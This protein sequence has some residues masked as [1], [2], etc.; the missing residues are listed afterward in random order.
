MIEHHRSRENLGRGVGDILASDIG[1]GAV[2][3]LKDCA[4]GTDVGA[5]CHAQTTHQ[6]GAQVAHD[7]AVQVGQHQDIE[8]IGVLDQAHAGGVDDLVVELDIGIAGGHLA[9]HAQE[10]AVGRLH[11][12]W[13]CARPSPFA[14]AAAGVLKGILH[15]ATAL[16]DGDRLDRDGG[17]G[18]EGLLARALDK[19]RELLD[20]GSALIEL[21]AGVE[22]LGVLA[23]DDQ[24][25]SRKREPSP[26]CDRQGRT[27]AYRSKCLRRATLT[28]RKPVPTGVVMGP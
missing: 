21:D 22:V 4:V 15:N 12:C 5:G 2:R 19:L 1:R 9:R 24:S 26:G 8:V 17:I 25:T 13:P 3:S 14:A 18:C 27:Q 20:L 7:V 10:Q 16:G 6:A 28:L 23:H 11:E